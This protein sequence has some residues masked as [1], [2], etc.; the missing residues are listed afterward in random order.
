MLLESERLWHELEA[1]SCTTLL[2]RSASS[3]TGATRCSKTCSLRW[4]A[5]IRAEFLPPEE[6]RRRWS[7]IRFDTRVLYTPQSGRLRADAA[8]AALRDGAILSGADVRQG[9]RATDLTV[10]GERQVRITT[11]HS[12][13]EAERVV[14]TVGAWT[15]KLIGGVV[16][17][18]G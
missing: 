16:P 9:A 18:P 10:L 14:V 12:V 15:Q 13:I 5:G 11:E 6:A 3:I 2:D 1:E 8:L 4:T 7:G 17:L